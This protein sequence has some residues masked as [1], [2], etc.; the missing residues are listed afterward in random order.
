MI[1]SQW[2]K[3][4]KLSKVHGQEIDKNNYIQWM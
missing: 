4:T 3:Y 2:S 1:K